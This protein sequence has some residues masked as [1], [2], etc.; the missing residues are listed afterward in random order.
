LIAS[1]DGLALHRLVAHKRI[2][3][4]PSPRLNRMLILCTAAEPAEKAAIFALSKGFLARRQTD[5]MVEDNRDHG[6]EA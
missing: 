3:S 2:A 6:K 1:K 5:D 4:F